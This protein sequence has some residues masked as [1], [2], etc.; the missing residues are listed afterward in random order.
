MSD[1][2]VKAQA[3]YVV[4]ALKTGKAHLVR[5]PFYT[6]IDPVEGEVVKLLSSWE[7][8]GQ[9]LSELNRAMEEGGRAMSRAFVEAEAKRQGRQ[10]LVLEGQLSRFGDSENGGIEVC[11][12]DGIDYEK[13]P[14]IVRGKRVRITIE[15]LP[16]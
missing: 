15:E 8:L 14:A 16:E 6:S 1:E 5:T 2:E 4:D 10:Y 9:N 7:R 13:V 11:F 12:E 3:D